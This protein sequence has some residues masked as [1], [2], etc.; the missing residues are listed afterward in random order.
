MSCESS[1]VRTSH[2]FFFGYCSKDEGQPHFWSHKI[3]ISDKEVEEGRELYA[4]HGAGD[5]KGKTRLTMTNVLQRAQHH[6]QFKLG[7]AQ[8]SIDLPNVLL[9]MLRTGKYY[10]CTR[11]IVPTQGQGMHK[12][13]CMDVWKC[14]VAPGEVTSDTVNSVFF[15]DMMRRRE[16]GNHQGDHQPW[17]RV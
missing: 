3:N 10:P 9:D 7:A 17:F 13:R 11:W 12:K 5:L 15:H 14:M 16:E 4:R 8:S 2:R 1:R 6:W